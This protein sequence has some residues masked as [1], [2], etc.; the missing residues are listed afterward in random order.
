[1]Q[2]IY[3]VFSHRCWARVQRQTGQLRGILKLSVES[4][5]IHRERVV[6]AKS[7]SLLLKKRN[8]YFNSWIHQRSRYSQE[9]FSVLCWTGSD[10]TFLV[11]HW[12]KRCYNYIQLQNWCT[13]MEYDTVNTY[14][15]DHDK[16]VLLL[17]FLRARRM[18]AALQR[19]LWLRGV[20][21]THLNTTHHL[22]L[23]GTL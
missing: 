6:S 22:R 23:K 14:K 13:D 16:V 2:I 5:K 10:G 18:K 4:P 8:V 12:N 1:M 7:W 19:R 11:W 15:V 17:R 3:Q 21:R 9:T 20:W